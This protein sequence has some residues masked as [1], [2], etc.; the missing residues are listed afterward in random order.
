MRVNNFLIQRG[1]ASVITTRSLVT[2]RHLRCRP[3]PDTDG[4]IQP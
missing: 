2:L 3:T 4:E 1:T